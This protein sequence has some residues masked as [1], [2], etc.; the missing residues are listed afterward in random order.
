MSG[1]HITTLLCIDDN[2]QLLLAVRKQL[3]ETQGYRV[4]ATSEVEKAVALLK[5]EPIDVVILDYRMQPIDGEGAA[6][7]IKAGRP[8]LPIILLSG[9]PSAISE[10]VFHLV[11]A[12][13]PK[14]QPV[15]FLLSAIEAML[16]HRPPKKPSGAVGKDVLGQS[17]KVLAESR[18]VLRRSQQSIRDSI[19]SI[20]DYSHQANRHSRHSHEL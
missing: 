11:D 12:F 9:F 14:G 7:R 16:G 8:E 2:K 15:E 6:L 20:E 5:R 18:R 13:V 10:Q 3:L 19:S 1:R 4:L 17:G